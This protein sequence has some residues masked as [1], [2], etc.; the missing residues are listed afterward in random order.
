M[1][2]K[3]GP[4]NIGEVY[5]EI[6]VKML[7]QVS[8]FCSNAQDVEDVVQEAFVK[9]IEAQHK[10]EIRNPGA[11]LYSAARNIAFNHSKSSAFRLTVLVGDYFSESDQLISATTEEQFEQRE[12]F[13][14]FCRA[15]RSLPVK[16]RRVYVLSR[17]YGFTNKEI[18]RDLG[19]SKKSVEGHLA[20]GTRR[21]IQF[22]ESAHSEQI[23]FL[24]KKLE[25]SN[26]QY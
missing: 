13:E 23:C 14:I 8:R 11:Y 20:R 21:C 1:E 24:R 9:V 16:C 4:A 2:N 22:M 10:S 19:I 6:R 15:V 12:N 5:E 17:V 7:R 18:A 25:L 3:K 26:E